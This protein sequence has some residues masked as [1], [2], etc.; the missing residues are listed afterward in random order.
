VPNEDSALL[1]A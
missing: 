1:A